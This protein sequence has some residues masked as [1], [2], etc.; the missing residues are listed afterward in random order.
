M[1]GDAERF[2]LAAQVAVGGADDGRVD[3][4]LPPPL[5]QQ[6]Q[7]V[8]RGAAVAEH[9]GEDEHPPSPR[10]LAGSGE[11]AG[12]DNQRPFRCRRLG[13]HHRHRLELAPLA[14][15]RGGHNPQRRLATERGEGVAA[16]SQLEPGDGRVGRGGD[17]G[18]V[19][20]GKGE[21]GAAEGRVAKP[22]LDPSGGP[23]LEGDPAAE[24][25]GA[26]ELGPRRRVVE[27]AGR[28][29]RSVTTLFAPQ[30]HR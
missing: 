17:A 11:E 19:G 30:R 9:V 21:A 5:A 15:D 10:A 22:G 7:E 4:P 12:R 27:A 25:D 26:L 28:R 13:E 1:D 29:L 14:G 2:Q 6:V 8:E 24:H 20:A 3:P 16:G 23:A 18:D